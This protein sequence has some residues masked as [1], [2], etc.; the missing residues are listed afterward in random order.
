METNKTEERPDIL[1]KPELKS[2]FPYEWAYSKA[3]GIQ[4]LL[5]SYC[6]KDRCEIVGSI[7]RKKKEVKDIEILCIP[8][9]SKD[10][11]LDL[12][13][14]KNLRSR[15]FIITLNSWEVIKGNPESGR[16]VQCRH[17]SGILIDIFIVNNKNY[18]V[19]KILRTGPAQYSKNLV[20]LIQKKGFKV[21]NGGYLYKYKELGKWDLIECQEEEDFYNITGIPYIEP[22]QR[23]I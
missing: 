23:G 13:I 11:E 18:G 14:E 21:A 1:D 3:L 9:T 4:S 22:E 5:L 12:F 16:Y 20:T 19:Q 2:L 7:R 17:N 8:K 10:E 6:V 15:G